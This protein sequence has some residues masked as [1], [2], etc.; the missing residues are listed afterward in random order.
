MHP[1]IQQYSAKPSRIHP[2]ESWARPLLADLSQIAEAYSIIRVHPCILCRKSNARTGVC[3]LEKGIRRWRSNDLDTLPVRDSAMN[4]QTVAS[5]VIPHVSKSASNLECLV[6]IIALAKSESN[7]F[8]SILVSF[9]SPFTHCNVSL[10]RPVI[11]FDTSISRV[12]PLF[13]QC[14][15]ANIECLLQLEYTRVLCERAF[16]QQ[17]TAKETFL[18]GAHSKEKKYPM[19]FK[20]QLT[21]YQ[22]FI[23]QNI[24]LNSQSGGNFAPRFTRREK[25]L[26]SPR[27]GSS[28][29]GVAQYGRPGIGIAMAILLAAS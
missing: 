1:I 11:S 15:D 9:F 20:T 28:D 27:D 18:P 12:I 24:A 6:S 2:R 8:S 26:D 7:W 4:S 17:R 21:R 19:I 3:G 25:F 16:H 23:N 10:A 5:S 14:D 29:R 22:Q 13:I